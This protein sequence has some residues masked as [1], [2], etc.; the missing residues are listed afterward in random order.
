MKT[1]IIQSLLLIPILLAAAC[2]YEPIEFIK[3]ALVSGKLEY[4]DIRSGIRKVP[5]GTRV[6]V[7]FK[8]DGKSHYNYSF[9]TKEDGLYQFE[10]QV[11]GTYIVTVML[12]D[13]ID[14][15]S[16]ALVVKEDIDTMRSDET[17]TVVYK[18]TDSFEMSKKFF[19]KDT[20]IITKDIS[21]KQAG[22]V[23]KIT[24]TDENKNPLRNIRVCI[25]NNEKLAADNSP[26][27]GG[28]LAY[29]SSDENGVVIFTGL[30]E[31]PYYANARG[32]VGSVSLDN[33]YDNAAKTIAK[34]MK[35]QV[36]EAVIVLK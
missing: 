16:S 30:E 24:L 14:Q 2:D 18:S 17:D 23:L 7:Q 29:L 36:N 25:Y 35:N 28:S 20:N 4:Q 10:P 8:S 11:E 22:T 21:L 31:R 27:C 3:P 5:A 13:T 15:F 6:E 9:K 12:V 33:Q 34:L 26:Y 1:K 19:K 32:N